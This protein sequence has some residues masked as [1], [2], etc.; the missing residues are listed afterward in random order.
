MLTDN[1]QDAL[2][3]A[4]HFTHDCINATLPIIREHYYGAAFELCVD[5][6][7]EYTKKLK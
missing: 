5:K 6:L 7:T 1:L 3:T 2:D 4:V